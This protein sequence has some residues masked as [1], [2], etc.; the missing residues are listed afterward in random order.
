MYSFRRNYY[1]AVLSLTPM[2]AYFG[3]VNIRFPFGALKP[4][5]TVGEKSI[6]PGDEGKI[7]TGVP[8]GVGA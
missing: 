5:A 3:N 6:C 8:D 1:L 2:P 7:I 4:L